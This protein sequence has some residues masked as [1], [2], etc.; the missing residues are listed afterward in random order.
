MHIDMNAFFA[1][2]E[3]RVNPKLRGKP[4]AVIGS[5][6]R[7]VITTASYE[8]RK[9]GVQTGMNTYEAKRLCPQIAFVVGDNSRY[10]DASERVIAI[11]KDFSPKVDVFS[12]DEAF[13][14]MTGQ[15]SAGAKDAALSIKE[16][17]RKDLC[18][19]CSIGIAPNKL[20]AKL[21]SDMEKPDGLVVIR[22]F[23][24]GRILE[25]LP[26]AFV[27]GIG[28]KTGKAL[29]AMGI[30]TC[31]ELS[32]FPAGLLR[33]RFGMFGERLSLMAKGIDPSAVVPMG[34]G[35]EAKSIGHSMTL[36]EDAS[37]RDVMLNFILMLSDMVGGRARSHGLK[38]QKVSLTL[39][40]PD[41]YTFTKEKMIPSPTN[42][43]H[44]I[45]SHAAQ[46]LGSLNLRASVRLIGVGISALTK[47]N[48][49]MGLF[50]GNDKR[51]RLL[52]ALDNVRERFGGDS[53]TWASLIPHSSSHGTGDL[54]GRVISPSWRPAGVRR[55]C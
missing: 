30:R 23:E 50:E 21:A 44:A 38:G 53:A 2:V 24:A 3:E 35:G 4:I 42:D 12:I 11:L 27:C 48:F 46:I 45:Y 52:C 14:D 37:N 36:S 55:A 15:D 8:A 18:L 34:Q 6:K 49:Q 5:S 29:E 43:T 13:I 22:D 7:T 51:A 10:T 41:F 17:I 47:D 26:A 33:A 39:R 54:K 16:R 25:N 19:T 32:R 28:P 1:S 9:Y 20:L 40:Y 31:G